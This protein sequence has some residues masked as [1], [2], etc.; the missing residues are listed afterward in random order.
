MSLTPVE[1]ITKEERIWEELKKR[2]KNEVKFGVIT[3]EFKTQDG[4]IV[5]AEILSERIKL[6]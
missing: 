1:A 6:G 2:A 4:R 5:F 3:V